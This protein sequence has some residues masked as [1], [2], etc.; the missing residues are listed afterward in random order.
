MVVFAAAFQHLTVHARVCSGVKDT[1]DRRKVADDCKRIAQHT[2]KHHLNTD[3]F[4]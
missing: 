1:G 3:K 4:T 2:Q